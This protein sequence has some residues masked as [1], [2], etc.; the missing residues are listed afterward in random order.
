MCMVLAAVSAALAIAAYRR[1][2][3]GKAAYLKTQGATNHKTDKKDAMEEGSIPLE[4]I[5]VPPALATSR[6]A[7][8]GQQNT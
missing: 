4:G 8:L 7:L 1:I 5:A 2:R 6:T 3:S